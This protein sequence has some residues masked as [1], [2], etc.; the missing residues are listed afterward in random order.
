MRGF[1]HRPS[2]LASSSGELH[3]EAWRGIHG[4]PGHLSQRLG[5]ICFVTHDERP[6]IPSER[7]S[8]A[9]CLC[10]SLS[11]CVRNAPDVD[12]LIA[13]GLSSSQFGATL[14]SSPLEFDAVEPQIQGAGPYKLA[15]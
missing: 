15:R 11:D 2:W 8:T 3:P 13:A 10:R 4:V 9:Q 1:V 6:T 14:F 7:Y 12:Y 5:V